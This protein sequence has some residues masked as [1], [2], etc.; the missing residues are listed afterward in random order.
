MEELEKIREEEKE[1]AKRRREAE[2]KEELRRQELRHVFVL[3]L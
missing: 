3:A 2:Q 1:E